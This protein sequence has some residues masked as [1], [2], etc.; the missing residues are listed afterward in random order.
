MVYMSVFT[1]F[2]KVEGKG[3]EKNSTFFPHN[4]LTVLELGA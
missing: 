2:L 1:L 4:D 3:L